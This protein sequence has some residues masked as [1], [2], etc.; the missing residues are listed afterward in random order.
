MDTVATLVGWQVTLV[1]W[2]VNKMNNPKF[3]FSILH[4]RQKGCLYA[5][6]P[7]LNNN[8]E[9][10]GPQIRHCNDLLCKINHFEATDRNRLAIKV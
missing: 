1:G 10:L 3:P 5:A 8:Y 7:T 6:Q 9:Y 2:Q 4:R